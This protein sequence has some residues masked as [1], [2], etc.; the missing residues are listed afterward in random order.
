MKT[1]EQ[2]LGI[3]P[4]RFI[5]F[6]SKCYGGRAFDTFIT[7]ACD[8]LFKLSPGDL[9]MSDKGF[10]MIKTIEKIITVILPKACKVAKQFTK[11]QMEGT[12]KIASVRIHVERVIHVKHA[13]YH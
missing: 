7:N 2:T 13:T 1:I 4:N 8:L 10:P 11:Q 6:V 5:Q 9:V 12:S 3:A